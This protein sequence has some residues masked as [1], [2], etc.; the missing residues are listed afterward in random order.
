MRWISRSRPTSE[1]S[2]S[3]G[4][5]ERVRLAAARCEAGRRF[6]WMNARARARNC[7]RL[8]TLLD[9][10]GVLLPGD[11]CG[12]AAAMGVGRAEQRTG[13]RA[14]S[15]EQVEVVLVGHADSAVKLDAVLE[16]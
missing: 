4:R 11:G 13:E 1:S 15:Q 6:F 5:S 12:D 3:S 8:S 14:P 7:S 16:Q 10:T 2:S 9:T